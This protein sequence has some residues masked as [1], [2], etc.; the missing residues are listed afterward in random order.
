[1]AKFIASR[2]G[3]LSGG[4]G[5]APVLSDGTDNDQKMADG[6]KPTESGGQPTEETDEP[7]MASPRLIPV[8]DTPPR[9]AQPS[10]EAVLDDT[11][12]TPD[13]LDRECAPSQA[14]RR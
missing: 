1:M 9:S 4:A 12:H 7:S 14:P 11:G 2:T 10:P 3:Q 8:P 5:I 13:S 6:E